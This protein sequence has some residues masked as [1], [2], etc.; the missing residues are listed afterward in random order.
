MMKTSIRFLAL[1]LLG[2]GLIAGTTGC[3]VQNC[4]NK[5]DGGTSSGGTCVQAKSL[6]KFVGTDRNK[7]A[8]WAS[9]DSVTISSFNGPIS[10]VKASSATTVGATF[11]PTDLRA[12]DTSN[13]DVQAD[14][15]ALSTTVT[16][17]AN[18]NVNVKVAQ[19]GNA[20]SGLGAE[21]TVALPTAFDGNLTVTSKNGDSKIQF[22]GNAQL[23]KLSS[24]N[25]D[26]N[27]AT[28]SAASISLDCNNGDVSASAG[29]LPAGAAGGTVSTGNGSIT[30]K[31]DGS[32]KFNVQASA[33]A[34][35]TVSVGNAQAAGCTIVA[36]GS[37]SAQT[38][39]CGGAVQGD[40]TYV[41]KADGTSLANVNL[42]F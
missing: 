3:E 13:A 9:G 2:G 32:Q 29:A 21:L 8:P 36:G 35:G 22:V 5:A 24:D 38:V 14:F 27:V 39:S 42:S 31:F 19:S 6:K 18:G 20:H 34:G 33:L 4:S 40:P 25:G 17:D 15:A 26:C 41:L 7:T 23:V 28:G 10:V 1:A 30:M 16:S 11:T 12:Y 37:D